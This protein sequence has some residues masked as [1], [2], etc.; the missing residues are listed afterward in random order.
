MKQ[1]TQEQL[2]S[3][4][5]IAKQVKGDYK[6]LSIEDTL[7]RIHFITNRDYAKCI[8]GLRLML[9]E[10][11]IAATFVTG[12]EKLDAMAKAV[13]RAMPLIVASDAKLVKATEVSDAPTDDTEDWDVHLIVPSP[14]QS[15]VC[16]TTVL[17]APSQQQRR[18]P[19]LSHVDANF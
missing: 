7:N 4:G 16:E 6:S 15:I 3:L 8:D 14:K 13:D 19:D 9:H 18:P 2:A 17:S 5:K 10:K 1:L 12:L 11:L